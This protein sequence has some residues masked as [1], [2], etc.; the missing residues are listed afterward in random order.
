MPHYHCHVKAGPKGSGAE[1]AQYIE[2]GGRFKAEK[3]GEIGEHERGNLPDW[4]R[5]SAARF[6][7]A[8]D[9]F[10]RANGNSYREFELALP[11]ELS[12]AE[13]GQLVREF[14]AEQLGE[15]HAYA[16]AIHE[17]RGH[18]PHVHIMFS[19]RIIDGIERGAEHY[20]KRANNKHPER[21]GHLK[22][23]RFTNSDGPKAVEALRAR[24]EEV[25]NAALERAGLDVRVDHRSL[26]A[27]GIDREAT[28]HRGPA[29]SGIEGRGEVADVSVRREA[30]RVERAQAVQQERRAVMTE[31][32]EVTRQEMALERVAA[33]ER[34]ELAAEVTGEDR[35]LVLPL[36]EADRREQ[37]ERAQAA[38]ERRVERRQGLGIGGRLLEQARELR[39][40]IGQQLGR[41]REWVRERFPDPIGQLKER[42]RDLFDTVA[43]KAQRAMGREAGQEQGAAQTAGRKSG[44]FDGLNL[45]T[46]ARTAERG[47]FAEVRLPGQEPAPESA[48]EGAQQL[49]R[50][51]DRYARAWSDAVRMQEKDLPILEHQ[52][53]AFREASLALDG[54][55]PG[56]SADLR[57]ALEYEPAVGQAMTQ[58]QGKERTAQLRAALD[59]EAR[60]R[61]DPNLKAERLVETWQGLEAQRKELSGYENQPAREQVKEHMKSL[62]AELKR[63]PQ[64]ESILQRRQQELG[65]SPGSRLD[66]VLK[67]PSIERALDITERDLGR[68][69]GLSL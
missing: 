38:A 7:A 64:L 45:K 60:V 40:R 61:A 53:T 33:R 15:R 16:W 32:R 20:F 17:P 19:E 11:V 4:A 6:F 22:S 36:V 21:G 42:S 55:R 62:A 5:G 44:M 48:R 25:Q 46:G 56:A 54:V 49:N 3:Y 13:R 14:V 26:E 28:R 2:R 34:R 10:E 12:D 27:Q 18:N 50:A 57:Q 69:R 37:I 47:S 24:W 1:H 52:R 59:H 30:E 31:V 43:Q 68:S 23:D 41:V 63:D 9:S 29:V 8:A 67:A 51:L 35:A 65:I 39:E 66:R 58:L